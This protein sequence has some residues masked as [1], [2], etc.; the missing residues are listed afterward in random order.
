MIIKKGKAFKTIRR[1]AWRIALSHNTLADIALDGL[2]SIQSSINA[3]IDKLNAAAPGTLP[4]DFSN[5]KIGVIADWGNF[6]PVNYESP[7]GRT[8]RVQQGHG[9]RQKLKWALLHAL[10]D[11]EVSDKFVEVID[12]LQQTH[13]DLCDKLDAQAG[14]LTDTD[15]ESVLGVEIL[16]ADTSTPTRAKASFRTWMRSS[17]SSHQLAN[18]FIDTIVKAE[19]VMN[20]ILAQLDTGS[21]TGVMP[22]KVVVLDPEGNL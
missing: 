7:I 22:N 8:S 4:V 6:K 15:F 11:E 9:H 13:D 10:Y 5:G 12:V 16:N 3:T 1:R 21:I 2:V 19:Q 14:T 17:L 18:E 20:Q